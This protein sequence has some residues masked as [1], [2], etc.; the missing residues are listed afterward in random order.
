[1]HR[2]VRVEGDE[3]LSPGHL[4]VISSVVTGLPTPHISGRAQCLH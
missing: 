2:R 4:E 1:M 3:S